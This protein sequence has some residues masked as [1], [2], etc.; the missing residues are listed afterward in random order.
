M[1]LEIEAVMKSWVLIRNGAEG[2]KELFFKIKEGF[3]KLEMHFSGLE[4]EYLEYKAMEGVNKLQGSRKP[5]IGNILP[6]EVLRASWATFLL[7][8]RGDVLACFG[9]IR[10]AVKVCMGEPALGETTCFLASSMLTWSCFTI[11]AYMRERP[12]QN[13]VFTT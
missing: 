7:L 10:S 4:V 8:L 13:A 6:E 11:S 5:D 9:W 3:D 12:K 1:L 2:T